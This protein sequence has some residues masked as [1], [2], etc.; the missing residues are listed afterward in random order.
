MSGAPEARPDRFLT[1]GSVLALLAGSL[2]LVATLNLGRVAG[3]ASAASAPTT[4]GRAFTFVFPPNLN[5]EAMRIHIS[6]ARS[7][8]ATWSIGGGATTTVNLT[9]NV[10]TTVEMP[11]DSHLQAGAGGTELT[12]NSKVVKVTTS[13]DAS[14]YADSNGQYISDATVVIPDANLGTRY[15]ALSSKIGS[16]AHRLIVVPIENSTTVT[17]TPKTVYAGKTAG[18]PYSVSL[19]AGQTYMLGDTTASNDLSG[20]LIESNKP[21]GVFV[22]A[23]CEPGNSS[24]F[25]YTSR[26][27]TGACDLLFEQVPP[28]QSLG[29]QFIFNGFADRKQG[30]TP[31]RIMADQ[32]STTVT[33]NGS[34]VATL[35]AGEV[36]QKNY[37]EA[38]TVP[39]PEVAVNAGLFVQTSKPALVAAFMRGAGNYLG[40]T[41]D[42]SF[43]YI[44]PFEQFLTSYTVVSAPGNAAQ[45]MN[46]MVP[47]SA[48]SSVLKDG[49]ALVAADFEN[50]WVPV[51]NTNYS[52][53][54]IKSTLGSHTLSASQAFGLVVYGAN[55]YNSYAYVGGMSLSSIGLVD[56]VTLS[57]Q[58]GYTG[59]VGQQICVQAVIL[60]AN[61]AG[62]NGVRVDGSI[63]GPNSSSALVGTSTASGVADLCYTSQTAGTDTLTLASNQ[64]TAS[65]TVVW[66]ESAPNISYSPTSISV[67]AST[68]MPTL[69]PSNSGSPAGSWTVS[70]AL[71]AGLNINASTGVISGT[72][73]S[74]AAAAN[75]TVTATN[76]T[77]SST[78]TVNI[79]VT[80]AAVTASISYSPSTLSLTLDASMSPAVPSV[81]G[82]FPTWSVSP[83]LPQGL[84]LNA[85]NGRV[86][87]T[88][89]ELAA[90]APYTVTAT[91]GAGSV[92]TTLTIAV[93]ATAPVISYAQSSVSYV[94]GTAITS[95]LPT[96]TGSPATSW[97]VSPA[98]PAGISFNSNTGQISGTPT[99]AA[100]ATNH[101][102]TATN[103]AGSS[104]F[105]INITVAASLSAPNISY[106]TSS[107]T[108]TVGTA[109]SALVPSNSGGPV[110]TWS[111]NPA[112]PAGLTFTAATGRISGTPS[113]AAASANYVITG[114][115]SSSSSTFTL[116]ITVQAAVTTTTA[117]AGTTTTVPPA[118]TTTVVLGASQASTTTSVP[119]ATTTTVPATTTT[120]APQLAAAGTTP[121]AVTPPSV[122][123]GQLKEL[124]V[125]RVVATNRAT[126][127]TVL[128]STPTTCISLGARILAISSGE[129]RVRVMNTDTN[130]VV[131]SSRYSVVVN[132][133]SLS[134]V[135]SLTPVKFGYLE[136]MPV[137]SVRRIA[138]GIG[139]A[140]EVIVVGHTAILTGLNKWND[141]L[142]Q[143]RAANI[144]TLLR[145]AGVKVRITTVGVG[146]SAPV[147]RVLSESEQS[148]NRRAVIYVVP[149]G[150]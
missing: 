126:R 9:A 11:S 114:T 127:E 55:S 48:T 104:T 73:S 121:A 8:T 120:A 113:V 30:G 52:V 145:R 57:T 94:V 141:Y 107:V 101:T 25:P 66:T 44:P 125:A 138:A 81:S 78:A 102:V 5:T 75:Y 19:N 128:S 106:S 97:S 58:A 39:S 38:A 98:L 61:G 129:C 93:V 70:P 72:P 87:G 80:A 29:R 115:N 12:I 117:P 15:R 91:N 21:V 6:S 67:V 14:V 56:S 109:M 50:S 90:S 133:S 71:P 1:L 17:L 22:S 139:P 99:I 26:A 118:T 79:E 96:N 53:A 85:Q 20:T 89:T 7:G 86:T 69:T 110:S 23:D 142:A 74:A 40:E 122:G 132:D 18:T 131:N 27:Q 24:S 149:A 45:L 148:R 77:G 2:A 103:S 123:P 59:V 33:V 3:T 51:S 41:G 4:L 95:L 111:V 10:A 124:T 146:G 143:Q 92:T 150:G 49:A 16:S 83:A 76:S 31:V 42:P 35:N 108:L 137:G 135:Y 46:L 28:V 64:L 37:W 140:K 144:K 116:N 136:V 134:R 130:K 32:N 68:A 13:V 88:P 82:T 54:Q 100:S 63:S 84:S 62:L 112:L 36:F 47:T 34:L 119:A 65:T 43:T 105:V 60:D 147:T